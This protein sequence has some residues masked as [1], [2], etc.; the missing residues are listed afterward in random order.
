[1][2]RF[3]FF[4]T[5]LKG[6]ML[7]QRKSIEDNRGFFNR[8]FCAEEFSSTGLIRPIAQINHS[9]T[10]LKGVVRGMHFQYPPFAE[11]KIVTCT[12]G[13][14]FDVA[15]DLRNKSPTFLQWHGEILSGENQRSLLIP[16]GFAHGFQTMTANCELFYIHSMPY[17][18][19]MEGALN[20]VDPRLGILW[21]LPIT[22][23]SK[24]DQTHPMLTAN[25]KG[26]NLYDVIDIE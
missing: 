17:M 16:Q 15:V 25:F 8:V 2:K 14:V 6:L 3:D 10:Y 26:I 21:P 7:V 13:S 22:Q 12:H 4:P 24:R 11:D 1:M 18:A 5:P 20:A 23:L 19:N 9:K